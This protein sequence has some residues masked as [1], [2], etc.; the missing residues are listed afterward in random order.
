VEG[1]ASSDPAQGMGLHLK[2]LDPASNLLRRGRVEDVYADRH[3]AVVA[4]FG[5]KRNLPCFW[6]SDSFNRWFGTKHLNAPTIGSEVA[7][8]VSNDQKFGVIIG[9]MNAAGEKADRIPGTI[10]ASSVS[11]D[12]DLEAHNSKDWGWKSILIDMADGVPSDV[13]P[14]DSITTTL[15]GAVQGT[16][17]MMSTIRG[18]HG[19]SIE[20]FVFDQLLRITGYNLQERTSLLERNVMEDG[21]M[22]SEE[23]AGTHV[24]AESLGNDP[25]F[26]IPD[27]LVSMARRFQEFEGFLGGLR[28]RFVIRPDSRPVDMSK[29]KEQPDIGLYQ[30]FQHLSGSNFER[31]VTGGGFI[32]TPVI[33]VPKK[34]M[35]AD[36]PGGSIG[37][38]EN[39]V[40][41][42]FEFDAKPGTPAG[43]FCQLR[44]YFAWHF[45]HSATQRL[46]ERGDDWDVPDEA[47]CPSLGTPEVP[48]IG[49]FY[50]EFPG[51]V[52]ALAG[53]AGNA[54]VDSANGAKTRLGNAWCLVLPDGSVSI[55]DIWGSSITMVG[56]H[57]D[58][59]ASKDVRIV[60]GGSV[61]VLGGDDCVIK[62][63]QSVDVSSSVG[64]IRIRSYGEMFI[65]SA[66]GGM[67]INLDSAGR[68]FSAGKK[69]EEM[70]LTGLLIKSTKGGVTIN[71]NQLTTNLG[72]FFINSMEDGGQPPILMGKVSGMYLQIEQGGI[73]FLLSNGGVGVSNDGYIFTTGHI[74]TEKNIY[75]RG[76]GIFGS[77]ISEGGDFSNV[78]PI[79][80][81][82]ND[83]FSDIDDFQWQYSLSD[84]AEVKFSFRQ[85]VE[86][87]TTDGRW[88]ESFWQREMRGLDEWKENPDETGEYPYPGKDHY[89]GTTESF[90][91]YQEKNVEPVGVSKKRDSLSHSPDGFRKA[92]FSKF[93][94]HPPR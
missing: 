87:A 3:C 90:W 48:G 39:A 68:S 16:L 83:V 32:K 6:L 42:P 35:D 56:G 80:Q 91:F 18:G 59:S 72:A 34:R 22:A 94:V 53:E 12:S 31:S 10:F 51:E 11:R 15:H 49:S 25:E 33:P 79:Q 17:E 45:N 89:D 81:I 63:R 88:F 60:S 85:T 24:M 44:D 46:R 23:K 77:E 28:Q 19:A 14:G 1:A 47:E 52:D 4:I 57:I 20:T 62:A 21:G 75:V 36:D 2:T 30:S 93:P 82:I 13:L 74:Y 84:L 86:Y 73:A 29:A 40:I 70:G 69:G 54:V 26:T 5:Y 27:N 61:V 9:A 92:S 37:K 50:R 65:S 78:D 71:S 58:L 7:V 43:T 55:R 38:P 76:T 41:K 8:I 66:V 67:L 64:Q